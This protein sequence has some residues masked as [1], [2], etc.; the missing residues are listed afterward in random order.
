MSL[1]N[2]RLQI[3]WLAL[4]FCGAS[5]AAFGQAGT[6]MST[7]AFLKE[8]LGGSGAAGTYSLNATD[9]AAAK[10]ILGHSYK[11]SRVRY[12][13]SGNKTGWVLDKIGKYKPITAGFVVD[14]GKISHRC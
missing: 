4:L 14:G 1:F 13:K 10:K 8:G 5:P 9:Q 7:S 2:H 6:Y 12:W 11:S 3:A